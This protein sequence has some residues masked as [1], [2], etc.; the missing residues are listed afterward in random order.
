MRTTEDI[1]MAMDRQPADSSVPESYMVSK[2]TSHETEPKLASVVRV[3]GRH[4]K[5]QQP[6][7]LSSSLEDITFSVP[8]DIWD[9]TIRESSPELLTL[10]SEEMIA[11]VSTNLLHMAMKGSRPDLLAESSSDVEEQETKIEVAESQQQMMIP[12]DVVDHTPPQ[13]DEPKEQRCFPKS[14]TEAV[15]RFFGIIDVPVVLALGVL[16]YLVDVGSD[17]MAGVEHFRDDHIIWGSLTIT[18]VVFPAICCAAFS[19]TYWY[20]DS[21]KDRHPTY[22]RRM[23]VLSVLLLDPLIR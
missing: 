16:L 1:D 11:P 2:D 9:L 17:I 4:V 5:K 8:S 10:P 6:S 15:H 13:T 12:L 22:R 14:P 3:G 21:N 7:A 19:W 18:F 23:M 20:Y